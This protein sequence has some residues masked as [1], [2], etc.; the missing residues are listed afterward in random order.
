MDVVIGGRHLWLWGI[1]VLPCFDGGV[2]AGGERE[3]N[4]VPLGA[5][6]ALHPTCCPFGSPA[7]DLGLFC[8]MTCIVK[9]KRPCY[10]TAWGQK[11]TLSGSVQ[12]EGIAPRSTLLG[13]GL[14]EVGEVVGLRRGQRKLYG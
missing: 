1:Y 14:E 8:S 6:P 3:A 4:P 2:G 7:F 13:E 10:S 5:P 9:A 11:A 12:R